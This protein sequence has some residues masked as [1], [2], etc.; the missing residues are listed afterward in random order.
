MG[1]LPKSFN[2]DS[3]RP[4]WE[5]YLNAANRAPSDS[6]WLRKGG[7]LDSSANH[8]PFILDNDPVDPWNKPILFSSSSSNDINV[9]DC[10]LFN[11]R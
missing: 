3:I 6:L 4:D 11:F 2:P 1:S 8:H 9:S 5:N 7:S 10:I